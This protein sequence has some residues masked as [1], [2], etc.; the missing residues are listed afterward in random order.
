MSE[1]RQTEV[2]LPDELSEWSVEVIEGDN[3]RVILQLKRDGRVVADCGGNAADVAGALAQA[4]E[5]AMAWTEEQS[6]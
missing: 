1:Q 5:Q 4:V 2:I 3:V 6:R